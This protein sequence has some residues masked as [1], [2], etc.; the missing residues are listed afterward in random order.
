[1]HDLLE[2]LELGLLLVKLLIDKN[3]PLILSFRASSFA[4]LQRKS[5]G[6]LE[7]AVLLRA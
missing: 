7:N 6:P 2:L 4:D 5:F 3:E 1:M